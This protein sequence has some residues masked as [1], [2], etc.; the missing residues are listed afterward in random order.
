M[1]VWFDGFAVDWWFFGLVFVR[2]NAG[3]ALSHERLYHEGD[4][5]RTL[6]KMVDSSFDQR[7]FVVHSL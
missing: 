6:L 7:F 2:S 1:L 5:K 4:A 3:A